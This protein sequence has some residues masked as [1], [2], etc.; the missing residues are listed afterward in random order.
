MYIFVFGSN[1]AGIHG[2]GA[3]LFAAQHFDAESGI[4]EGLTGQAYAIPTKDQFLKV[5]SLKDIKQSITYF[6]EVATYSNEKF[7]VTRVGCGLAGYKDIDIA[8][9]FLYP[10]ANCYFDPQWKQF[11]LKSW[12][13]DW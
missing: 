5:R 12:P 13:K 10:P 1:L 8:P 9:L 2:A 6:L 3:A 11:G 7:K 4:G